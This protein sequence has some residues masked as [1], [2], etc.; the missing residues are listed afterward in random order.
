MPI[1]DLYCDTCGAERPN[2]HCALVRLPEPEVHAGFVTTQR[3]EFPD[4]CGTPMTFH[5]PRVVMDAYEPFQEFSTEVLQP[6]GSHK[7]VLV[8]S[9]AKLRS[10]EHTSEA[11]ARNGEGQPMVWRDYSQDPSNFDVNTMGEPDSPTLSAADKKRFG[12]PLRTQVDQDVA[13]GP[14]VTDANVSALKE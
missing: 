14:G 3:V 12:G 9:L 5:P 1:H 7:S 2:T 13:L 11:R 10:I 8:D 4:C 6:D